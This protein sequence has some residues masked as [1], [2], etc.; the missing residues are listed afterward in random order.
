MSIGERIKE[1]RENN[2]WSQAELAEKLGITQ[3]SISLWEKNRRIPNTPYIISLAK[4][5]KISTD[6]LLGY[7]NEFGVKD[8][9][10]PTSLYYSQDEQQLIATYRTLSLGKK[11]ALFDMLDIKSPQRKAKNTEEN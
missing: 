6:Y 8:N 5:F 10:T 4:L 3:D 7:E 11:K 9:T 2:G 1:Q